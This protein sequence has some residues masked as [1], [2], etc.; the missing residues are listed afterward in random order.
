MANVNFKGNLGKVQELKFNKSDGGARLGFSVAESHNR[1]DGNGGWTDE[2]T[3]WW[4]VTVFG[5]QAEALAEVLQE[6]AKQKLTVSGRSKTREYEVSGETR[7]SL[8]VVAD[9]VGIIPK[10]PQGG[11]SGPSNVG[12]QGGFGQPAQQAQRPGPNDPW[13]GGQPAN[14]N[15]DWGQAQGQVGNPPF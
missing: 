13:S 9:S 1:P 5:K 7:S 15:Y 2:G 14:G 11:Q 6:G 8:D 3:T 12:S 10:S 4:N